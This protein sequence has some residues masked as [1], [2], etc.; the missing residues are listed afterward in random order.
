MSKISLHRIADAISDHALKEV[1]R[2][3]GDSLSFDYEPLMNLIKRYGDQRARDAV[4]KAEA[5]LREQLAAARQ[6]NSEWR[7]RNVG[8]WRERR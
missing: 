6:E 7:E 8:D 1:R 4:K 5:N 2:C 3:G